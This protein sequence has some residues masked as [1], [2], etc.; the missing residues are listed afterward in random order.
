M[1]QKNGILAYRTW[2]TGRTDWSFTDFL[3]IF[4]YENSG[5]TLDF[6]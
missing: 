5:Y 2:K 6:L 3:L 1:Y 4:V